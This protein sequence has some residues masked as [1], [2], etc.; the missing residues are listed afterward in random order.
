MLYKQRTALIQQAG[1]GQRIHSSR[2]VAIRLLGFVDN[3]DDVDFSPCGNW[4][5]IGAHAS[6]TWKLLLESPMESG[7]V[8]LI[9]GLLQDYNETY[10]NKKDRLDARV[11]E[12]VETQND[13]LYGDGESKGESRERKGDEWNEC[14]ERK[15]EGCDEWNECEGKRSDRKGVKCVDIPSAWEMRSQR[16][17]AIAI[18]IHN[19]HTLVCPFGARGTLDECREYVD[20]TVSRAYPQY[21]IFCVDMYEWL[22]PHV[23]KHERFWTSVPTTFRGDGEYADV[24]SK[25]LAS[26]KKRESLLT[27]GGHSSIVEVV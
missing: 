24:M 13:P 17:A 15:G 19:G 11:R 6:G 16:Y 10:N 3:V 25:E 26:Q 27:E 8:E 23:I 21:D 5:D 18:L 4:G 20:G 9:A 14:N 7:E 22:Y 2:G 1:S 12:S